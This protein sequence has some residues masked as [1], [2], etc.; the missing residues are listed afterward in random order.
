MVRSGNL[1][2]YAC[3]VLSQVGGIR[4]RRTY[5]TVNLMQTA[6]NESGVV[7][8]QEY[9]ELRDIGGNR[10][11][12]AWRGGDAS[13]PANLR[14]VTL[15]LWSRPKVEME[16]SGSRFK[17]FGSEPGGL[18]RFD[19]EDPRLAVQTAKRMIEAGLEQTYIVGQDGRVYR[20]ADFHLLTAGC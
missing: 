17:I 4:H 1:L 8:D 15:E 9:N 19:A 11:I 10:K 3:T 13:S 18:V 5:S 2:K 16:S 12:K 6:G 7:G 20:S 14:K